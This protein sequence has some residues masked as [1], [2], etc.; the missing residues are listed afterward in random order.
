MVV[1]VGVG[2]G[3]VIVVVAAAVVVD[4]MYIYKPSLAIVREYAAGAKK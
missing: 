1:V 2:V 4:H 3:V